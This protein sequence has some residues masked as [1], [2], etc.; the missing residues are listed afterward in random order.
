MDLQINKKNTIYFIGI[1]GIGMSGI[2]LIMKNLGYNIL[3]SDLSKNNKILDQLKKKGIK[4]VF[5]HNTKAILKADIVV[6][7]SAI[8]K[9]NA[10]LRLAKNNKII[11]VKRADMLAH[12]INLKKKYN[13]IRLTW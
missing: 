5:G 1:G 8:Q 10:E 4:I 12:L 9:N 11:I 13:Y 7:S 2:A 6:V 3:G